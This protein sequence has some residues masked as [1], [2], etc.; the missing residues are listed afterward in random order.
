[1]ERIKDWHPRH[2]KDIG[3]QKNPR[4]VKDIGKLKKSS[5]ILSY[6]CSLKFGPGTNLSFLLHR[7][8]SS[9]Q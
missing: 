7:S 9:L 8:I 5:F 2:V 6:E 4:D 1:M 3:N